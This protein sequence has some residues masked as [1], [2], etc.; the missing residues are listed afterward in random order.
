L[1]RANEFAR[2]LQAR[3]NRTLPFYNWIMNWRPA[4]GERESVD[5]VGKPHAGKPW[6]LIEIELRRDDPSA[7]VIKVWRWKRQDG[8]L[9]DFV[10]VQAFSRF[11]T[12]R[13]PRLLQRA[14]FVGERM[15]RDKAGEYISIRFK[16]NPRKHGRVGGG[17]RRRNARYL[18][19]KILRRLREAGIVEK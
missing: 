1:I 14:E 15:K 2:D 10:L 17:R 3:L 7:N 13:S 12:R 6:L 18:A 9:G 11:Y 19:G 8:L 16:Y 4:P 5:L